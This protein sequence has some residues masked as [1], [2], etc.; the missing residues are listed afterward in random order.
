MDFLSS[1]YRQQSM[2]AASVLVQQYQWERTHILFACVCTGEGEGTE[3]AGR[4]MTG[5]LLE[6]FRGLDLKRPAGSI[7]VLEEQ[8]RDVVLRI[9]RE[10]RKGE[11]E[12]KTDEFGLAGIFCLEDQC[13]LFHRG[14]ARIYLLNTAF[15]R[16]Y[17]RR[18]DGGK[19]EGALETERGVLQQDIGMLFATEPFFVRVTEKMLAEGLY[20]GE[21][22]TEEQMEKHLRE[23][24]AA[25]EEKG[26]QGSGAV[27][28][29][30]VG[31]W[32][33]SRRE[34]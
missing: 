34:C 1:F 25:G 30:M 11:E 4:Y 32:K 10:R 14:R 16:G 6:W 13:V 22:V 21:T 15:G 3:A 23:L 29:R 31:S 24:A 5:G 7:A 9:G 19:E 26:G 8:L 17:A 18:L 28:V 33:N 2:K 12:E 27:Y 20:V